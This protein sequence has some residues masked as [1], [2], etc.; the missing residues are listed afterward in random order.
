MELDGGLV[1]EYSLVTASSNVD[2][3]Y[4]VFNFVGGTWEPTADNV[5]SSDIYWDA[6]ILKVDLEK[7]CFYASIT[8]EVKNVDRVYVEVAVRQDP[9]T[10]IP[11]PEGIR[12]RLEIFGPTDTWV[13]SPIE[14]NPRW[15]D[16][17]KLRIYLIPSASDVIPTMTNMDLTV[18]CIPYDVCPTNMNAV[19]LDF[20]T[21]YFDYNLFGINDG[22]TPTPDDSFEGSGTSGTLCNAD[23]FVIKPACVYGGPI[24]V[25]Q[26]RMKLTNVARAT[27]TM[28][29]RTGILNQHTFE[30]ASAPDEF[31]IDYRPLQPEGVPGV[32]EIVIDFEAY[33]NSTNCFEVADLFV[34]ACCRSYAFT[35]TTA[36]A[37]TTTTAWA[38]ECP[39]DVV[40]VVLGEDTRFIKAAISGRNSGI[41]PELIIAGSGEDALL[42]AADKIIV[43]PRFM[44]PPV[45]TIVLFSIQTKGTSQVTL[46]LFNEE[47]NT[48]YEEVIETDHLFPFIQTVRFSIPTDGIPLVARAE[49][50]FR[51]NPLAPALEFRVQ[52]L[53]VLACSNSTIRSTTPSNIDITTTMELTTPSTTPQM[54]YEGTTTVPLETRTTTVATTPLVCLELDTDLIDDYNTVE[55]SSNTDTATNARIDTGSVWSPTNGNVQSGTLVYWQSTLLDEDAEKTCYYADIGFKVE[56]VDSVLVEIAVRDEPDSYFTLPDGEKFRPVSSPASG[57]WLFGP[58]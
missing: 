25:I 11:A 2:T 18:C 19:H 9:E 8:F 31:Y 56:N 48:I 30:I 43:T 35:T 58:K 24:Q 14:F 4:D 47:F 36:A 28:L 51:G 22:R 55:A 12:D 21:P 6:K 34:L 38:L 13:F 23:Y 42:T 26:V 29:G 32:T 53:T 20:G 40:S 39:P 1:D 54:P 52:E 10:L 46:T 15:Y 41:N 50:S 49:V 44:D 45:F 33:G 7:T 3:A 5:Q 37:F 57:A 16:V 27:V 17:V